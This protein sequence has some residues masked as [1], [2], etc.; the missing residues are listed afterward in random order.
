[1]TADIKKFYINMPMELYEY[2]HIKASLIPDSFMT[3]HELWDKVEPNGYLYMES[4]KGVYVLPQAGRLANDLL[5][6]RLDP[7][8]Y[9]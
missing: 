8:G 7:R 9:Y 1:M 5:R 3:E 6:E 4:M 2:A